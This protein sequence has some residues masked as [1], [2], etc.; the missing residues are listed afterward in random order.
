LRHP[1]EKVRQWAANTI[2]NLRPPA[3]AAVPDLIESL[4]DPSEVVREEA[5]EAL[6]HIGPAA[7]AAVDGL[8]V[9]CS[10]PVAQVRVNAYRALGMLG[11]LACTAIPALVQRL[12]KEDENI[13]FYDAIAIEEI[14]LPD[15]RYL[16]QLQAA[17]EETTDETVATYLDRAIGKFRSVRP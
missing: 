9:A 12:S 11:P 5:C 4:R 13:R 14:G 6:L 16:P 17:L 8:V 10:D 2:G 15:D 1:D 3:T 7:A